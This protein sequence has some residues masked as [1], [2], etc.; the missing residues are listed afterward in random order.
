MKEYGKQQQLRNEI[1]CSEENTDDMMDTD[2]L[3]GT[4]DDE[5]D[6]VGV[7][8]RFFAQPK[9]KKVFDLPNIFLFSP[10]F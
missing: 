5:P 1:I 6:E 7:Y 4:C 2:D 8:H 3:Y 9:T 10:E